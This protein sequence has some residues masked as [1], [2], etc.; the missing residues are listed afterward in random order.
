MLFIL[1]V[2]L[3]CA[4]AA[5]RRPQPYYYEFDTQDG[6]FKNKTVTPPDDSVLQ[7]DY[8]TSR[9]LPRKYFS[10][11]HQDELISTIFNNKEDGYFVDLAAND[12]MKLS[13]TL[14]LEHSKHW[15]G[16]CIEPNPQYLVG[17]LLNRTC[18]V[19]TNP[20]SSFGGEKITFAFRGV[21]SGIVGEDFD[22]KDSK[23]QKV[24]ELSTVTFESLLDHAQAP[25]VIDYLSLDVEGAEYHVLSH[26]N[27]ARYTFLTI[28]IERPS[29]KTHHLLVTHGYRHV[30]QLVY[31]GDML[32]I[33]H[34]LPNFVEVMNKYY[35]IED[36]YRWKTDIP[37]H[38]YL[39]HPP[40]TGVFV[41]LPLAARHNHSST[42]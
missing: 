18:K 10:Q 5:A 36:S 21:F 25:K 20:V 37:P 38:E 17:L 26:F 29:S 2:F 19:Y 42:A 9:V 12:W 4:L 28:T 32:Y 16:I 13:N 15:N 14:M 39:K 6:K 1:S 24:V 31:F 30:K 27:F 22:N 8:L 35:K 40:W 11:A 3:L 7:D 33:H 34:T 41:P 23:D